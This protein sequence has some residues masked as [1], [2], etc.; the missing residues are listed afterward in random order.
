VESAA[1]FP[2]PSSWAVSSGA[3]LAILL[4]AVVIGAVVLSN[5]PRLD[6]LAGLVWA[7]LSTCMVSEGVCW[8]FS[9]T[10]ASGSL[11][12]VAAACPAWV[13]LLPSDTL[14]TACLLA[15]IRVFS[16]SFAGF[17]LVKLDRA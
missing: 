6:K 8:I 3:G 10:T 17:G 16:T 5:V 1:L 13:L 4:E 14:L 12:E 15:P 7:V 9:A 2:S 11:I